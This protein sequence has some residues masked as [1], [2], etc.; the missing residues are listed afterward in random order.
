MERKRER[1]KK[2]GYAKTI[3][4]KQDILPE[5]QH[6]IAKR[7]MDEPKSIVHNKLMSRFQ[8]NRNSNGNDLFEHLP[9]MEY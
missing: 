8:S 4:V 9:Y 2:S 3:T 7:R 6:P 1:E 5:V